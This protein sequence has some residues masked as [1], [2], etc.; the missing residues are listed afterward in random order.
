M[1]MLDFFLIRV[2]L[3]LFSF[4]L[5]EVHKSLGFFLVQTESK[6]FS[7]NLGRDLLFMKAKELY[8]EPC[9]KK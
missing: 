6:Y 8:L 9:N 7:Q 3:R 1:K 4:S 5:T 2:G